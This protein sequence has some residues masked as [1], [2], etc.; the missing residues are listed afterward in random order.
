MKRRAGVAEEGLRIK[1]EQLEEAT[2]EYKVEEEHNS[3]AKFS[4]RSVQKWE[5]R[6][7]ALAQATTCPLHERRGSG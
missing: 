7:N 1:R 5:Q 2:R 4:Q 3:F 6:F